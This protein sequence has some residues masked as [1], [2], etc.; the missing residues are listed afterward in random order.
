MSLDG[1]FYSNK[2]DYIIHMSFPNKIHYA[3]NVEPS[4]S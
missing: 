3:S 2:M 1:V 4:W